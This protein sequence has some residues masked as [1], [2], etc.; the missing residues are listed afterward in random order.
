MSW[1]SQFGF[2]PKSLLAAPMAKPTAA[3]A[4]FPYVS[5]RTVERADRDADLDAFLRLPIIERKGHRA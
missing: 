2:D 3:P 5:H 1:A 4:H